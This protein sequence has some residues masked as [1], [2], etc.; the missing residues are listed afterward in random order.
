MKVPTNYPYKAVLSTPGVDDTCY[1]DIIFD[2]VLK[3][4]CIDSG[5]TGKNIVTIW[6]KEPLAGKILNIICWK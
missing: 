6:G 3:P 2:D 1:G 4:N 5:E